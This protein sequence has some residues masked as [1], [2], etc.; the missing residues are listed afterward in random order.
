MI[1]FT[2]QQECS[3][4]KQVVGEIYL[5]CLYF[6]YIVEYIYGLKQLDH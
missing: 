6:Q 5:I 2:I 3:I 4:T 1:I